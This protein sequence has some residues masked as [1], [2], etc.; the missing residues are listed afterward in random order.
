[1]FTIRKSFFLLILLASFFS[2]SQ[3]QEATIFFKDGDSIQGFAMIKNEKIKFRISLDDKPDT[4]DSESVSKVEFYGFNIKKTFEY[5]KLSKHD[6][7]PKLLEVL[8]KDKVSL[9]L[10]T[11][12]TYSTGSNSGRG[13]L[14]YYGSGGITKKVS[15]EN[16]YVKRTTDEF[17]TCINCYVLGSW[18]KKALEYFMDCPGLIKKIN[19]HELREIHLVDIVY[20]YND[21]CVDEEEILED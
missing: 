11:I 15:E 17:P 6:K 7:K 9:Y 16:H 18:K 19:N 12:Y 14:P 3:D 21:Y 13:I 4:W 20:F 5:V 1:M 8:I 10:E 2:F